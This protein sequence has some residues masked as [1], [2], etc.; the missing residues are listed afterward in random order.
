MNENT[1]QSEF[2]VDSMVMFFPNRFFTN[3]GK[4]TQYPKSSNMEYWDTMSNI[5]FFTAK[6]VMSPKNTN[7]TKQ[8]QDFATNRA[9]EL[10]K[11]DMSHI[12]K[13]CSLPKE[14]IRLLLKEFLQ[15]AIEL[16]KS[17]DVNLNFKCG[18]LR[19]TSGTLQWTGNNVNDIKSPMA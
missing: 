7:A 8:Q 3:W 14:T 10:V 13:V 17:S 11:I 6:T 1:V 12:G 5:S 4:F 9:K 2:P 16:A 15:K 19:L 18:N